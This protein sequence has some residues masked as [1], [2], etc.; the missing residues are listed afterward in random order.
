M[1]L[2][3]PLEK[4]KPNPWQTRIVAPDRETIESLAEDIMENTMLQVPIGRALVDEGRTVIEPSANMLEAYADLT[5]ELAFGHNRLAAYRFN[6]NFTGHAQSWSR[7]PV[8]V[9]NIGHQTMAILSW[10]ENEKRRDVSAYERALAIKKRMDDFGWSQDIIAARL[11][12]SR[13]AVSNSLRLLKLPDELKADLQKGAISERQAM[14]LLPLYEIDSEIVA[15]QDLGFAISFIVQLAREGNSSDVLR[16]HVTNLQNNFKQTLQPELVI[17]KPEEQPLA[18]NPQ[19]TAVEEEPQDIVIE[20]P[21]EAPFVDIQVKTFE[22]PEPELQPVMQ[23]AHHE[24]HKEHEESQAKAVEK[25]PAP[26]KQPKAVQPA[27]VE[28]AK[29]LTWEDS[30]MVLTIT[31]M[32]APTDP[33]IARHAII[34][35]RANNGTPIIRMSTQDQLG[36]DAPIFGEMM[37]ELRKQFEVVQ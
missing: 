5:V 3:I 6:Y 27:P 36:I 13:P 24:G 21:A 7:M 23:E 25:K 10:S 15:Q 34:S 14:A 12:I 20:R 31:F 18:I 16:T 37:G 8:E 17:E 1:Q 11:A 19:P 35:L 9:R 32:P 33:A 4:I 28:P 29:A 22:T 2:L 30:T 26:V